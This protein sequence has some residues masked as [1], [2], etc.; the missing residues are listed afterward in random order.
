MRRIA[1]IFAGLVIFGFAVAS[2]H[3]DEF[4]STIHGRVLSPDPA[5]FQ[6]VWIVTSLD[7]TAPGEPAL[8]IPLAPDGSFSA[9]W[10]PDGRPWWLFIHQRLH[11]VGGPP[12]DLFLPL[13][14]RAT[15][16]PPP[17]EGVE[18]RAI[19]A[20][21]MVTR[22]RLSFRP[23]VVLEMAV[24]C[25]L[26][27]G[28]GPALRRWLAARSGPPGL[29]SAPLASS[30]RG[31][32]PGPAELLLVVVA[33]GLALG[34]RLPAMF[35]EAMDLLEVSY[36]P[37]IGRPNPFAE[38][39]GGFRALFEVL[40]ELAQLYCLDLVHPPLYHAVL[41]MVGLAGRAD[42]LLRVPALLVS[43]LTIPLLW[44]L[45]RRE[46]HGAA[47]LSAFVQAVA[48]ASI[49][50][51]QD[52]T[53]YALVN[54]CVVGATL[55]VVRGLESGRPRAWRWAFLLLYVGFL[56]HYNVALVGIVL[57][58]AIVVLAWIH[59]SDRRWLGSLREAVDAAVR[60][61]PIPVFWAWFHF[62]TFPTVAQDTRL[63][64]DTFEPDPG[65]LPFLRDFLDVI[66]GTL[67]D[68]AP[69]GQLAILG[70]LALGLHRAATS[71]RRPVLGILLVALFLAF[72]GSVTFF[73]ENLRVH[74]NGRVYYGFRW[75]S[76]FHPPMLGILALGVLGGR[77]PAPI[78]ALLGFAWLASVLGASKVEL[79]RPARPDYQAAAR[80]IASEL[81]DGDGV[82]TLPT[83]FQ[84]GN[85]GYYLMKGRTV[86]RAPDEGEGAW[87]IGGKKVTLEPIHA[88]LPFETTL[89]N[90]HVAR[91]WLAV[92]DERSFGRVKWM[93]E[94][95]KAGV[96]AA[97]RT[98]ERDG[99]WRV[100]RIRLLRY[101]R[102]KEALRLQ[103]GQEL[104]LDAGQIVLNSR[105]YPQL[106][107]PVR[108]A[109]PTA[110]PPTPL[111]LTLRYH[112]PMTPGCVDW[113]WGSLSPELQPEAPTH[114]YLDAR[115]P[116]ATA[117][118]TPDVFE[119]GPAQTWSRREGDMFRVTAV[120]GTCAGP[121]LRLRVVGRPDH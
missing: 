85:L 50:W 114:W 58:G 7:F 36:L 113:V 81:Q 39:Q 35:T 92:V 105:T 34:L 38:G 121:P 57:V 76:W 94:V 43:V 119:E 4:S 118:A 87:V 120:G 18:L 77:A 106:P 37:G 60:L 83:W 42:A 68:G 65:L 84:R 21:R 107:R 109:V 82:A 29:P 112:A 96:L 16:G 13:D 103:P 88:G 59:R 61:G 3:A 101:A 40:R 33:M 89:V 70:L 73:H 62:S 54:L 63:F 52:A 8:R 10:Q 100:G 23:K 45:L 24:I 99:E 67:V 48:P 102:P 44:A 64:A 9:P 74:L 30:T 104:V 20:T 78:R 49:Y 86:R 19:D 22:E 46:H 53:P 1:G 108:L 28:G 91:L 5:S 80:I 79:L 17:A 110:A 14:L 95:A 56:S 26:F 6:E 93:E 75:V 72:L 32:P 71:K 69:I 115:I 31:P 55:A 111:G 98:L 25:L 47:V 97:D 51:G 90:S 11:P 12:M 27:F 41:G 15:L 117:A 2:A 116:L 66:G